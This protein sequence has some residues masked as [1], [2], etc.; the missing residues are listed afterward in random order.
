M[1]GRHFACF[2]EL[3]LSLSIPPYR[4]LSLALSRTHTLSLPVSLLRSTSSVV[5]LAGLCRGVTASGCGGGGRTFSEARPK[6]GRSEPEVFDWLED[7]SQLLQKRRT[8]SKQPPGVAVAR[9]MT[10]SC[11]MRQKAAREQSSARSLCLVWSRNRGRQ[12]ALR[13]D[14]GRRAR[15]KRCGARLYNNGP[16]HSVGSA[17]GQRAGREAGG[18]IKATQAVRKFSSSLDASS[19][20]GGTGGLSVRWRPCVFAS[21]GGLPARN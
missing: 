19:L 1:C 17:K 6:M 12:S 18:Q 15:R 10:R 21:A 9:S 20:G 2:A 8:G 5:S 4:F 14:A 7:S 13:S 16:S 11:G 3:R